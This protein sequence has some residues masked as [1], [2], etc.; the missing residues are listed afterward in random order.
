MVRKI[1][2]GKESHSRLLS[3]PEVVYEMQSM[4]ISKMSA[5]D[6]FTNSNQNFVL[7]ILLVHDVKPSRQDEYLEN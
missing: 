5:D 7:L 2:P 4:I 3:D 1:D 6:D